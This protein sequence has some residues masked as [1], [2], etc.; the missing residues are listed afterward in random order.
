[1]Q[2]QDD[3]DNKDLAL[4]IDNTCFQLRNNSKNIA[5]QVHI[6]KSLFAFIGDFLPTMIDLCQAGVENI[7]ASG[8]EPESW[9]RFSSKNR[10]ESQVKII[11]HI[12]INVILVV[13]HTTINITITI[14]VIVM[15]ITTINVIVIV[16]QITIIIIHTTINFLHITV[17]AV[18]VMHK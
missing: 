16:M 7:D 1:M 5:L 11:M 18:P 6:E 2:L 17:I 4:D 13:I 10:E 15:H 3:L 12:T 8:S 9:R 14:Y